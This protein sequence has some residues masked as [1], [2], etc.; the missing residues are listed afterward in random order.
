MQTVVMLLQALAWTSV[1]A[2]APAPAAAQ[3]T[4][5]ASHYA[6][7]RSVEIPSLSQDEVHELRQG[8]GM[9]LARAAE[10]N[11]FPGPMHLLELAPDLSLGITQERRIQAIFDRMKTEAVAK[12]EAILTAELHL[13]E[14]FASGNPSTSAIRHMTGH[15]GMLRG[16][17]QAV[18]LLAHIEA[19]RELTAEQIDAYDRLRGYVD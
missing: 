5:A 13:S 12:G 15:I 11:H 9:G 2:L 17:L 18:H 4:H 19:T 10:L 1:L 7:A 16:E 8:M 6:H 3:H 14:L